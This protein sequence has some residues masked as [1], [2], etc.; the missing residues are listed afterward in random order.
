[1][2]INVRYLRHYIKMMMPGETIT[3]NAMNLSNKGIEQLRE[4]VSKGILE[5]EIPEHFSRTETNLK[6]LMSG[7]IIAPYNTYYRTNKKE[8]IK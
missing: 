8:N 1:M 3:I 2:V 4:Y 6:E 5:P 7:I